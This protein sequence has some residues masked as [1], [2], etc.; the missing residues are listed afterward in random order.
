MRHLERSLENPC[1]A[2]L[3]DL[4]AMVAR[5]LRR[6]GLNIG[7]SQIIDAVKLL[8]NYSSVRG[9]DVCRLIHNMDE[10]KF[11][12]KTVFARNID[13]EKLVDLVVDSL[14]AL[15]PLE[16]FIKRVE[17]DLKLLNVR[18]GSKIRNVKT[19]IRNDSE[20]ARAYARLKLLGL[21][22]RGRGYERVVSKGEAHRLI[23]ML[24]KKYGSYREALDAMILRDVGRGGYLASFLGS[25]V[26]GSSINKAGIDSLV[27]LANSL[28]KR[29]DISTAV[30]IS[31]AIANRIESGERPRKVFETYRLLERFGLLSERIVSMLIAEDPSLSSIAFKYFDPARLVEKVPPNDRHKIVSQLARGRSNLLTQLL[32][33]G[34]IDLADLAHTHSLANSSDFVL[35][36][37]GLTAQML[38]YAIHGAAMGDQG[39]IEM[40]AYLASRVR[41]EL[42]SSNGIPSALD[43]RIR[44]TLAAVETFVSGR[45]DPLAFIKGI[46]YRM[47]L[48]KMLEILHELSHS[49]DR[50]ISTAARRMLAITVSRLRRRGLYKREKKSFGRRGVLDLRRAIRLRFFISSD[51]DIAYRRVGR[52]RV[53]LVLDKSG[54]MRPYALAGI[55]AASAFATAVSRIVLF[56][57]NVYV[58]RVPR[59]GIDLKQMLDIL[60]SLEFEGFTDAAKAIRVAVEGLKPGKIVIISDL[61][62]TVIGD[63]VREALEAIVN[64]GWRVYILAP[65]TI[66]RRVIEGVRGVRLALFTSEGDV[67]RALR[68]LLS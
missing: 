56:D 4:V 28:V 39:Y 31:A 58:F 24:V 27:S 15:T 22:K 41:K 51:Y 29:G 53:V 34:A 42:E 47:P 18:F 6:R 46:T 32:S 57:S 40:A 35:R 64:R 59:R 25:E 13:D 61:R 12:L 16:D 43:T 33:N 62:Q 49:R 44:A 60:F 66:D 52:E 54:S 55:V 50:R 30:K 2:K 17:N 68:R 38:A 1:E 26:L 19:I 45:G 48:L 37:V 5:E 10:L 14:R 20:R 65:P 3:L 8:I 67:V 23:S 63:N 9:Y 21:I 7:T 11:V 36:L